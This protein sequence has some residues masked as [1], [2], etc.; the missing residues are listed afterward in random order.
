MAVLLLEFTMIYGLCKS[1]NL[2]FLHTYTV[3]LKFLLVSKIFLNICFLGVDGWSFYSTKLLWEPSHRPPLKQC[4]CSGTQRA[5]FKIEKFYF[6]VFL[7]YHYKMIV[8]NLKLYRTPCEY[9]KY[10]K[11]NQKLQKDP[12]SFQGILQNY[13]QL[14]LFSILFTKRPFFPI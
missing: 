12:F 8:Y 5:S 4:N 13:L 1:H 6:Y 14:W 7:F 11:R 9:S 2:P 3:H 10:L